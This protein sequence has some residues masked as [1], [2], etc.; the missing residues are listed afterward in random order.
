MKFSYT[1]LLE[2]KYF[3]LIFNDMVNKQLVDISKMLLRINI[4]E[5]VF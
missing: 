2:C 3:L 1:C 5:P 4:V